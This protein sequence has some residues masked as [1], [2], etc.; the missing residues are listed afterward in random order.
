MRQRKKIS[1]VLVSTIVL[2]LLNQHQTPSREVKKWTKNEYQ[3]YN[4]VMQQCDDGPYVWDTSEHMEGIGS[5]FQWRKDSLVAAHLLSAKWIG[6]LTNKHEKSSGDQSAFFG[7][8]YPEC[9]VDVLRHL[10]QNQLEKVPQVEEL[11]K[12]FSSLLLSAINF[13]KTVFL[14]DWQRLDESRNYATFDEK[15][16]QRFH[17]RRLQRQNLLKPSG[18][19]WTS[20]HFR[21]GDVS[22]SNVDMPNVRAGLSLSEFCQCIKTVFE[23]NHR[24]HS[25][26][27]LFIE[28]FNPKKLLMCQDALKSVTIRSESAEWRTDLDIMS[29]SD[30]LIGGSSS[31]FVL[32]AHLCQNCTVIHNSL[33]KF[34]MSAYEN[35]LPKHMTP[36][37][38]NNLICYLRTIKY[39]FW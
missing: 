12:Y 1:T 2:I 39:Q 32:G 29:Q 36:M 30:L 7:L 14:F 18:E 35:F 31:F 5:T 21:W 4:N 3:I 27:F 24:Y 38:C 34:K 19:H 13:K 11:N 33:K 17:R 8:S 26:V 37:Y 16:R 22:T 20:V 6:N 10:P 28:R 23:T 15:F 9:N 25:K